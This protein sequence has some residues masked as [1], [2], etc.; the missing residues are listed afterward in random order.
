MLYENAQLVQLYLDAY[1]ISGYTRHAET[2]RDIF[3]YVLRDLTHP[4]GG[5]YS[6]EDADSA[7]DPAKPREKSEGAFYIWSFK[8]IVDVLGEQDAA[9]FCRRFGVQPNGNVQEDPHGEF[10]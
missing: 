5:F 7:A 3:D 10:T 4:D 8:E 1:L 6:A 2:A 9:T